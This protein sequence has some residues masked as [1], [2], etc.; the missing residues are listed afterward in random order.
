MRP[1]TWTGVL[2]GFLLV[3]LG[4][5][6]VRALSGSAEPAAPTDTTDY[7]PLLQRYLG[8]ADTVV[9]AEIV[10]ERTVKQLPVF[11]TA[12]Q[13]EAAATAK[14]SA[15]LAA[16]E[17]AYRSDKIQAARFHREYEQIEQAKRAF[18]LSRSGPPRLHPATL[19]LRVQGGQER[20]DT[21]FSRPSLDGKEPRARETLIYRNGTQH[22]LRTFMSQSARTRPWPGPDLRQ[23]APLAPLSLAWVVRNWSLVRHEAVEGGEEFEFLRP[24]GAPKPPGDLRP[25]RLAVAV[26]SQADA[27]PVRL[28][29]F[30][31]NGPEQVWQI[32]PYE[33]T[34]SGFRWPAWVRC[35][36]YTQGPDPGDRVPW[37][38]VSMRFERVRINL[39][40]NDAVFT[41]VRAYPAL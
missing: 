38:D 25:C 37:F 14:F 31:D 12:A 28:D 27:L 36:M 15:R 4:W 34:P 9:S 40:L 32:G 8:W 10:A 26:L 29:L 22:S 16:L 39:D 21:L 13:A 35:T 3:G 6:G 33:E 19:V 7:P 17:D 23:R 2:V 30:G 11:Q 41:D 20:V 18:V 5:L 1:R 24:E